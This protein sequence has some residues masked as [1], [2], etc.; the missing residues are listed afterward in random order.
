MDE[1]WFALSGTP[2]TSVDLGTCHPRF[3]TL[4]HVQLMSQS[5]RARMSKLIMKFGD[6][7]NSLCV[8]LGSQLLHSLFVF[9]NWGI[10]DRIDW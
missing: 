3:R 2:L 5:L 7:T 6:S 9:I 8:K 10:V 4:L 1:S